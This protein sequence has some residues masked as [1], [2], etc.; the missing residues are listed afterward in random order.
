MHR[1]NFC[2]VTYTRGGDEA[3]IRLYFVQSRRIAAKCADG[4]GRKLTTISTAAS[5]ERLTNARAETIGLEGK[6]TSG[7]ITKTATAKLNRTFVRA[8]PTFSRLALYPA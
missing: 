5:F 2:R 3:G 6:P 4:S 7:K 8:S 1:A